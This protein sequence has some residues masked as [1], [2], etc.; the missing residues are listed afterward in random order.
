[1]MECFKILGLTPIGNFRNSK[2]FMD[3]WYNGNYSN[4][5]KHA[6][7]FK[8]FK[9]G[10]WCYADFYRHLDK[11]FKNS[12]FILTVRDSESWFNS[13]VNHHKI[14][15]RIVKFKPYIK[16]YNLSS[17]DITPAS[18]LNQKT[19]I[20]DA[21]ENRNRKI[22]DYFSGRDNF[23]SMDLT[24]TN[25]WEPILDFLD[26]KEFDLNTQFPHKNKTLR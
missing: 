17:D 16:M 9:D 8:I 12:K 3:E 19:K 23:L 11:E 4:L 13:L 24:K 20:I 14:N 18:L 15:T 25:R 7:Q 26:I 2:Q 5:F 10:P 21:Y 22:L 6:K 1:M